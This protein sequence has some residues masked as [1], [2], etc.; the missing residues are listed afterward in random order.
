MSHKIKLKIAV[1]PPP[2]FPLTPYPQP[3][4]QCS[5]ILVNIFNMYCR[6]CGQTTRF[7]LHTNTDERIT[8]FLDY[9]KDCK[10]EWQAQFPS[11]PKGML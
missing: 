4:P 9:H 6:N 2:L 8:A 3:L 1:P 11:D 7:H 5:H 10:N